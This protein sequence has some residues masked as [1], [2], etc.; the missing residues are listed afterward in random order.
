MPKLTQSALGLLPYMERIL[1]A[2]GVRCRSH[3]LCSIAA[4]VR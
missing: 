4:A 3:A 2:V 1:S